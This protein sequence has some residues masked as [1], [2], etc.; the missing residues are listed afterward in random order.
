MTAK[1]TKPATFFFAHECTHIGSEICCETPFELI[2]SPIGATIK[3]L[4]FTTDKLSYAPTRPH[5]TKLRGR[6][7]S[8]VAIKS[9]P[10]YRPHADGLSGSFVLFKRMG[11]SR[12]FMRA[13]K[14]RGSL[15]EGADR[16][17]RQRKAK[18]GP[19]STCQILSMCQDKQQ[20]RSRKQSRFLSRNDAAGSRYL[21]PYK[22]YSTKFLPALSS[23]LVAAFGWQWHPSPMRAC[24]FSGMHGQGPTAGLDWSATV[25][26]A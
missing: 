19:V 17:R 11:W 2:E 5:K 22:I 3:I 15:A 9:A 18:A 7:G 16:R 8:R 6:K 4:G 24:S 1:K 14:R 12:P 26:Q 20:D 25:R 13:D 21:P 10:Q 23:G